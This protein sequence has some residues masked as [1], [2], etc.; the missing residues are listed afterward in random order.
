MMKIEVMKTNSNVLIKYFP[1]NS[2]MPNCLKFL[3]ET[4]R[5]AH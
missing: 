4:V 5:I 3:R 1:A 2:F